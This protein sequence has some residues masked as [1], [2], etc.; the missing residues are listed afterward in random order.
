MCGCALIALSLLGLVQQPLAVAANVAGPTPIQLAQASDEDSVDRLIARGD[1]FLALRDIVSARLLFELAADRGNAEAAAK[2]GMTYDP[3]R[4]QSMGVFG[5]A[6]DSQSALDWYEKAVKQGHLAARTPL[7]RLRA[8]VGAE[9]AGS[10][11]ASATPGEQTIR[12][13]LA[14]MKSEQAAWEEADWLQ[15]TYAEYLGSK[16]L[17][18]KRLELSGDRGILFSVRVEPFHDKLTADQLCAE[19]HA[20]NQGCFVVP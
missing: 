15:E 14:A 17:L 4:L 8:Y 6:G 16:N 20:M 10:A 5:Y 12:I 3:L 18:V 11:T 1:E 19:F 7:D 2:L 9:L 13:Q